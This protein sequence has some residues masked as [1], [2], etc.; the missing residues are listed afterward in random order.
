MNQTKIPFIDEKDIK[1]KWESFGSDVVLLIRTLVTL[2]LGHA[3]TVLIHMSLSRSRFAGECCLVSGE[4]EVEETKVV[5]S[6]FS[7][8]RPLHAGA[9]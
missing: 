4:I 2:G 3:A 1:L 9:L 6:D 5:Y 8:G 7:N